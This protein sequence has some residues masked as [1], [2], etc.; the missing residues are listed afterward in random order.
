MVG[1]LVNVALSSALRFGYYSTVVATSSASGAELST[2][3][4]CP[5]ADFCRQC[6]LDNWGED[7]GDLAYLNG[8]APTLLPGYGYSVICEG[9]GF[10][11]VNDAGECISEDC[12]ERGHHVNRITSR[13]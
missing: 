10:I 12:L 11:L 2:G 1:R 7:N 3:Q 4:E 5:V 8:L 9:C 6:A 13:T